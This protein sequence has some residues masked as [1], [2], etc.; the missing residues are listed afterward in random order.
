MEE[1]V[2]ILRDKLEQ[3]E[4]ETVAGCEFTKGQLAG[5]EVILLKSGIGK[6][7]AAMSTT[8]L[9]ERYKPEKSNQ[10]WFSWWIPS[11]SKCWR[12]RYFN[13]SSSP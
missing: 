11:F 6:V 4:T 8:I 5:H 13:R 9:L 3:A 1:E 12:C 2:R 7:N 10:Y